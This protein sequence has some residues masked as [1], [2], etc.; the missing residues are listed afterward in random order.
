MQHF[1]SGRSCG[2]L[3]IISGPLG[4]CWITL[5]KV[6]PSA[7]GSRPARGSLAPVSIES[8]CGMHRTAKRESVA[9]AGK[10]G[11]ARTAVPADSHTATKRRNGRPPISPGD[12]GASTTCRRQTCRVSPRGWR[13]PQTWSGL[14]GIPLILASAYVEFNVRIHRRQGLHPNK[15]GPETRSIRIII[16][17]GWLEFRCGR[18]PWSAACQFDTRSAPRARRTDRCVPWRSRAN[19]P[20]V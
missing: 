16:C 14:S 9:I 10:C 19:P 15:R 3:A 7:G 8:P 20:I 5:R 2:D 11:R 13:L 18:W 12:A 1:F 6:P 4:N 17:C